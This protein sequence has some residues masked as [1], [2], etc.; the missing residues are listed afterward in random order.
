MLFV[1]IVKKNF[2]PWMPVCFKGVSKGDG[3]ELVRA[4][5]GE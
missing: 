2:L 5:K 1:V 3:T 4:S